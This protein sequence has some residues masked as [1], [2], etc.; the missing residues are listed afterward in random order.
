MIISCGILAYRII[1][2]N[3]EVFLAHPGGPYFKED[4]NTWSIPKGHKEHLEESE[5]C[6]RR[7]FQE[8]TNKTPPKNL[9]FFGSF[10]VN[11]EKIVKV[12]IGETNFTLD[13][14]ISNTC[15]I[16]WK[17]KVITI[18]EIDDWGWFNLK[19]ALNRINFGQKQIIRKFMKEFS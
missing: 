14:C 19:E 17:D 10:R 11:R 5:I 16:W 2:G 7:E 8:E 13:G 6:A 1:N 12:F 18:P 9:T 4:Y 3:K 15:E